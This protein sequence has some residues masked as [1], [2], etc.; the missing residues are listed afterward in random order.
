MLR[1]LLEGVLPI[2]AL[3]SLEEIAS[4]CAD[5]LAAQ[6][7]TAAAS[8][9]TAST[10][11]AACLLVRRRSQLSAAAW[12]DCGWTREDGAS[13]AAPALPEAWVVDGYAFELHVLSRRLGLK[14][15]TAEL[16]DLAHKRLPAL[17]SGGHVTKLLRDDGNSTSVDCCD[18]PA[19]APAAV[20]MRASRERM[21]ARSR[22]AS[23]RGHSA[24]EWPAESNS[25]ERSRTPPGGVALPTRRSGGVGRGVALKNSARGDFAECISAGECHSAGG[26]C[27]SAGWGEEE[28]F[29]VSCQ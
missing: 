19:A 7:G 29:W 8:T 4:R 10:L 11:L 28:N 6:A 9:Q 25:A 1:P 17:R 14:G 2:L 3:S 13:A 15:A 23:S 12:S 26:E 5:V 20:A 22:G 27:D 21:G 24:D 16:R 18:A